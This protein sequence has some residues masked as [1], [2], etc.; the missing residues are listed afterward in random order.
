[1]IEK[2]KGELVWLPVESL[3]QHPDNPR[4][5]LGDLTELA[6]SIKAKG[7][8]QNLTV[9]PFKSKT[10]P[11]FNGE[12]RYTI[13]IGHRRCAAAKLAGL[14]KVPCVITEMTEREQIQ[15]MLLENMQRSDLTTYEQAQGFQMM[16]DLGET[17][18]SIAET[19]GFSASTVSRRI[20]LLSIDKKKFQQDEERG[21]TLEDYIKA[22]EI[23]DKKL[24][25]KVT[26]AIGTS[27]FNWTLRDAMKKQRDA[28]KLPII[29]ADMKRLGIKC[30]ENLRTWSDGYEVV[31]SITIDEFESGCADDVAVTPGKE[32]FWNT[33]QNDTVNIFKKL[34]KQKKEAP[35]KSEAEIHAIELREGLKQVSQK[36]YESRK[37]FILG[38]T[39]AKKY[40]KELDEW[41]FEGAKLVLTGAYRYTDW[42]LICEATGEGYEKYMYEIK[43]EVIEKLLEESPH[44]GKLV[45][46]A[47]VNGGSKDEAYFVKNYG[48]E[49]PTWTKNE[50]LDL[51]Y[52]YLCK[53]GYEMSDEEKALQDGSHVLFE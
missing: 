15:T 7:I 52:K 43:P 18:E 14:E 35:K 46:V 41:A 27:N 12:G 25:D 26:D 33:V 4:K 23:E 19:T 48:D 29:K 6:E 50:Y 5:E 10:N 53:I 8:L 30:D 21:A 13:I 31:K 47:A 1:M 24:R 32:L 11:K 9:V 37:E 17:K 51:A 3:E 42:G 44:N 36:A 40:E 49:V 38:F 2:G 20:K 28:K 39:A 45:I 22:A 34:P 16:L